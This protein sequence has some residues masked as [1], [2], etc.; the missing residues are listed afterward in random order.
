MERGAI[1]ARH[2]FLLVLQKL[3]QVQRKHGVGWVAH[4]WMAAFAFVRVAELSDRLEGDC[5]ARRDDHFEPAT[6]PRWVGPDSNSL[7]LIRPRSK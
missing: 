3:D 5:P 7:A 6:G 1:D 4:R 2:G